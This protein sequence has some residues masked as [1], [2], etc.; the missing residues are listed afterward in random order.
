MLSSKLLKLDPKIWY[1]ANKL[2]IGVGAKKYLKRSR[3][4]TN[5]REAKK[6]FQ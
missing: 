1:D 2:N 3:T 6:I 5:Y 4:K